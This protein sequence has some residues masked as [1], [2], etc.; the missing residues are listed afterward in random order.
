MPRLLTPEQK[1][2]RV[3]VCEDLH[4]QARDDPTFMSRI[5]TSDESWVYGYDPGTKQKSSQW[6]SPQS[7]RPKVAHQV[8]G[9]IH[10][11]G[12][13]DIRRVVHFEFLPRIRLSTLSSTITF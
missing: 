13:F 5:I 12:V 8:M 6:K 9:S 1:Q 7:P 3:K 11:G 10:A 2:H 4:R